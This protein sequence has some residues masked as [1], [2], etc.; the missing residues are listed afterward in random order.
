MATGVPA[1]F[2]I[3]VAAYLIDV[4]L[5]GGL[6]IAFVYL[7][8]SLETILDIIVGAAYFTVGVGAYATTVGKRLLGLRVERP[9]GSRVGWGRAFARYW[10]YYASTFL[11]LIGYLMVAFRDDKRALHDLICDTVVVRRR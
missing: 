9:D 4:L 11:L 7:A 5:M 6:S 10:A 2:W 3:R 1:G 8:P